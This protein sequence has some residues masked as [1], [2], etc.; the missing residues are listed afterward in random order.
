MHNHG[1]IHESL[2]PDDPKKTNRKALKYLMEG[3]NALTFSPQSDLDISALLSNIHY[4][5]VDVNWNTEY[6]S[7][8][9]LSSTLSNWLKDND[10]D[11]HLVSGSFSN[12][13][14]GEFAKMGHW[15]EDEKTDLSNALKFH[16]ETRKLFPKKRSITINGQLYQNAGATVVQELAFMLSHAN[17]YLAMEGFTSDQR[18]K[19]PKG[20]QFNVSIGSDYFV[21][22]AK[23]RALRILWDKLTSCYGHSSSAFFLHVETTQINMAITDSHVNILRSTTAAMSAVSGGADSLL[24]R[25]FNEQYEAPDAFSERI[26]R[27]IHHLLSEEAHINKSRD[28]SAGSYFIEHLTDRIA[29]EA[30]KKFQDIESQGGFIKALMKG[31][32]QSD[33]HFAANTMLKDVKNGTQVL[34]GVNKYPNPLEKSH[35]RKAMEEVPTTKKDMS[36]SPIL[37]IKLEYH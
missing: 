15:T 18:K 13:P 28:P 33:I 1:F 31:N 35:H 17:E 21:E 30:W 8:E 3:T 12:D 23:L 26:A 11:S 9:S 16:L 5:V 2:V 29:E 20:F 6:L 34:I 37:P 10:F 27:N 36:I 22:M 32:V 4:D 7:I 25:P 24:I 19:L 14:I